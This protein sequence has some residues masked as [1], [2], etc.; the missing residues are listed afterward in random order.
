MMDLGTVAEM[1]FELGS[2]VG[3]QQVLRFA[4]DD[5]VWR[6]AGFFAAG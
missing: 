4:Q 6:M 5:K 2:G 3:K 1:P